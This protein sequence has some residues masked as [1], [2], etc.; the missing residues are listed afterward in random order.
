[1]WSGSFSSR[2]TFLVEVVVAPRSTLEGRTLRQIQFRSRYQMNVR[3]VWHKR[4]PIREKLEDLQLQVG[5]ALLLPGRREPIR[6]LASG[7]DLIVLNEDSLQPQ[8]YGNEWRA[9]T[10]IVA[11]LGAATT[12]RRDTGGR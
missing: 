8:R 6:L 3:A 10:I 1:L 11:T 2:R 7:S 4:R 12:G 5:D 9:L